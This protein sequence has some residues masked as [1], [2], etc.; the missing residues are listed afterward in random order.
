MQQQ[1]AAPHP[2]PRP[3]LPAISCKDPL[4]SQDFAALDAMQAE[5]QAAK[6]QTQQANCTSHGFQQGP[7]AA[8][9][10]QNEHRAPPGA[11]RHPLSGTSAAA[12]TA[13]TARHVP[14][15][16]A[17]SEPCTALAQLGGFGGGAGFV[18][19]NQLALGDQAAAG[20][21]QAGGGTA[22]PPGRQTA[23][24]KAAPAARYDHQPA[25][26]P[27]DGG[28]GADARDAEAAGGA[29]AE[30]AQGA[31]S[32]MDMQM[33]E[34]TGGPSLIDVNTTTGGIQL[35]RCMS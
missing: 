22:A 20:R 1:L 14:P 30:D 19:A 33:E 28:A 27:S 24:A 21:P 23:A 2:T 16:A 8:F 29:P 9:G 25:A 4:I 18:S 15:G 32:D 26:G 5:Y 12:A 3:S 6:A 31:V 13:C 35:H 10:H 11:A 17:G 34:D 7:A